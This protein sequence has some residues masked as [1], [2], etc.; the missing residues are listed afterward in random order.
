M[1]ERREAF[2]EDRAAGMTWAA[3]AKKHGVAVETARTLCMGSLRNKW[4]QPMSKKR[5]IFPK[6]R[7]WLNDYQMSVTALSVMMYGENWSN[8]SV[9]HVARILS[10]AGKLCKEDIDKILA[11]T[12]MTYEEA[13][14]EDE[15]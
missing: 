1:L 2:I 5:C 15:G 11:I 8:C 10:G 9:T 7:V 3:I 13:F 4:F 12:K 14:R 6:L